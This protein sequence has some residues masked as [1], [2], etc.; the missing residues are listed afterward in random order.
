MIILVG[1]STVTET[2]RSANEITQGQI[3]DREGSQLYDKHSIVIF[4]TLFALS[5]WYF[6]LPFFPTQPSLMQ[7]TNSKIYPT[8][9]SGN[10][11]NIYI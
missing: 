4:Q 9:C 6:A 10:R 2:G 5:K 11:H 7:F 3:F 8:Q 1:S